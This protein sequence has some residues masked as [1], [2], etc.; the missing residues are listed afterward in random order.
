MYKRQDGTINLFDFDGFEG[1]DPDN[2]LQTVAH[3]PDPLPESGH[4]N[5][6]FPDG[7]VESVDVSDQTPGAPFV[8]E[9]TDADGDGIPDILDDPGTVS[10]DDPSTQGVE[11][12]PC[13]HGYATFPDGHVEEV[14]VGVD[15]D[16]NI[17]SDGDGVSD[18]KEREMQH[19]IDDAKERLEEC[20]NSWSFWTDCSDEER[21]LHHFQEAQTSGPDA[22]DGTPS[23][24]TIPC[25]SLIHI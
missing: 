15:A 13:G 18:A 19:D 25:L 17:D 10:C 3:T 22:G 8:A 2:P 23:C 7:H 5:V 21:Q 20:E 9:A 12:P 6:T 11:G 16:G 4:M 24:G 14:S 1:L